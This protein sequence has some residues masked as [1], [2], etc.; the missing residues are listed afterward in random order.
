ML[1]L[2]RVLTFGFLLFVPFLCFSEQR[3]AVLALTLDGAIHPVTVDLLDKALAEAA[4]GDC[5][6]VL[7]RLN[8]PGGFADATRASMERILRSR[9]P[10][11]VWI[12]PTGARAASAGFFLLQ[13]SDIAAMAPGTNTGAAHPV[14][15]VGKPDETLMKKIE[16]DSAASLRSVMARRGRNT[17]MGEQAVLESRSFTDKEA[18]AN[19]L[20]ELIAADQ[21]DLLRQLQGQ[22]IKRFDGTTYML[23]LGDGSVIE[24]QPNLSQRVQSATSDPNIAIAVL[25]LG[26]LLLYIEFSAPGMVLPGVAGS[27]LFIV[28]LSAL[29]VLP[30]TQT[31]ILLLLLAVALF[32][33]ELKLTSHGVLGAG[34]ILSMILGAVYLI[35]S[36]IPELRV[37]LTTALALALPFAVTL[38]FLVGL[39]LRARRSR[40]QM[41]AD[42]Y[43]GQSAQVITAC[44]PTGH[45]LFHGEIWSASASVPLEPGSQARVVAVRGLHL[46]IEPLGLEIAHTKAAVAGGSSL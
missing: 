4:Q 26:A 39:V 27:I 10:V 37:H 38:A 24:Y 13:A 34:A 19:G 30:V 20:I 44:A 35:D 5:R 11:A 25:L 28:G 14:M 18:M 8:T 45:V 32:V 16:S 2:L 9:V 29:S 6:L 41:G 42:T 15:L 40:I 17:T 21:S 12:G 3:A 33:L 43:V 7:I 31:G 36:P 22:E 1:R 23:D 46:E